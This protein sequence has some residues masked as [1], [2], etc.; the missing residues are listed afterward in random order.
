[1]TIHQDA[2]V[3][4][5]LLGATDKIAYQVPTDRYLWLHVATGEVSIDG[6]IF[7][8]GDAIAYTGQ[9]SIELTTQ[10]QGEVLLFD[11]A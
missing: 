2:N 7:K 8:A 5:G 3:Y 1:V 6:N 9:S 10:S 11:L 4:V